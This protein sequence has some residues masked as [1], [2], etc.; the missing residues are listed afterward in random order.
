MTQPA[1]SPDLPPFILV[2]SDLHLLTG[3]DP[4]TG[5]V[6]PRENFLAD[7][8]FARFLEAKRQTVPDGNPLL[9]I[10]GDSMDFLRITDIPKTDEDFAL[11]EAD[12]AQIGYH[13]KRPLRHTLVK[14]ERRYGLRTDDYKT[15]WKFRQIV[16]GH[17]VFF[18]ALG[19]WVRSG[20]RLVFLKGNH[21]LEFHWT[22]LQQAIRQELAK[23]AGDLAHGS[24]I[25]FHEDWYQ[26]QNVYIE[27][28]HRFEA[29]TRVDGEPT[30][31][32]GDEVRFP[33]GSFFNKFVINDL[34]K[35]DPFLDNIKPTSKVLMV[36]IKRRPLA[37]FSIL[38][39][40]AR[41][42][43]RVVFRERAKH[44]LTLLGVLVVI[45][46]PI[47]ILVVAILAFVFDPVRNQVWSLLSGH[48]PVMRVLVV[49][50]AVAPWL[51]AGLQ[52]VLRKKKYDHGD[53][54][55]GEGIY[56]ALQGRTGSFRQVYGIVGHTHRMDSQDLGTVGGARC[57]YLNCGSWTPR[58]DEHRPDLNGRIEYSFIRLE[59][60]N[61]EYRHRLLEWRDDRG[62]E[63]PALIYAPFKP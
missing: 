63:A 57:F 45:A 61:G 62:D 6:N 21:D 56:Q 15:V 24:A 13:P 55:Y 16:R 1:T 14:K 42:L 11:W 59:L 40:G 38:F 7:N 29:M 20:G 51:I 19:E 28:G 50:A 3:C 26:I 37:A 34:E 5:R 44:W 33:F 46:L 9:V 31:F 39:L 17:P 54:E 52:E 36:A 18:A 49:V 22:L 25:Q 60:E 10:N 8:A 27:H 30:I 48:S 41:A 23:R 2:V 43:R 53:D 4:V 32:R 47:V 35:L 58:W 12:L